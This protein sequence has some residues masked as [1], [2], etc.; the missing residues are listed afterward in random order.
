MP[1]QPRIDQPGLFQHVVQRRKDRRSRFFQRI[2]RIGYLDE[3]H[4]ATAAAGCVIHAD[5][6]MSNPVHPL[7]RR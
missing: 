1:R 2:G 4:I 3:L 5:L 6:L 7:R